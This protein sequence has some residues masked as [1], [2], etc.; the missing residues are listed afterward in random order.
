MT[1]TGIIMLSILTPA[2]CIRY[3]SVQSIIYYII[4]RIARTQN[5]GGGGAIATCDA[6]VY[7]V[8]Q[9]TQC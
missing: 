8:M 6:L 5:G 7:T 9:Y 4:P 3:A 1:L 2:T